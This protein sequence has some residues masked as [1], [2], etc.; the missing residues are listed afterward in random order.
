M[1]SGTSI[2][3]TFRDHTAAFARY[4][5]IQPCEHGEG[6][7]LWLGCGFKFSTGRIDEPTG[8]PRLPPAF[9]V[10]SGAHDV[11]PTLHYFQTFEKFSLFGNYFSRIPIERNRIGY[12]F[13]QEHEI[14]FGV[15]RSV[16]QLCD[17]VALLLSL[18]YAKIYHDSDFGMTLPPRVRDGTLVLNTGGEFLN[19][20]PGVS[21][22]IGQK[23]TAQARF[24]LPIYQ[25]WNG[26]RNR[27]VGQVA[28]DFITQIT[29][30]YR[31]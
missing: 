19:I 11:I 31:H 25:D 28:P 21:F 16:P 4:Q 24:L 5:F 1:R 20:T 18:D 12:R 29:L 15:R 3:Q 10:G 30:S 26:Q 22:Q 6:P 7:Q 17:K 2:K 9:Q 14:H 27:N 13:G 8:S 23:T